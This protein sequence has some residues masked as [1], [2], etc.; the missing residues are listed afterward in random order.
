MLLC[1]NTENLLYTE[2]QKRMMR[3]LR[4]VHSHATTVIR[5]RIIIRLI[6]QCVFIIDPF[7][8]T[9]RYN[10]VLSSFNK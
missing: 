2:F 1:G 3:A 6:L 4:F 9:N 5:N 7:S 10:V 8:D